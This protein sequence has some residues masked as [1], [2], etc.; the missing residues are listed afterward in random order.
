MKRAIWNVMIF[1]AFCSAHL[2]VNA[3]E[4]QNEHEINHLQEQR[5]C[6]IIFKKLWQILAEATKERAVW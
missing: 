6:G 2:I 3:D 4:I 5:K 1:L